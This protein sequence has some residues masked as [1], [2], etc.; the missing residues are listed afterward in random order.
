M[1]CIARSRSRALVVFSL[2]AMSGCTDLRSY[3]GRWSGSVVSEE[4]VRQGFAMDTLADPLELSNV[5]LQGLTASLTLSDGKFQETRLTR[6]IRFSSD[7]MASLSFEG[8]PL[9][10]YL[11]FAPLESE[12]TGWPASVV[13]SL[14]AD[15]H[16]ELRIIRGNDLFGVFYLRRKA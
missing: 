13:I 12:P 3:A 15:D 14:F 2:A 5:D 16:V 1:S 6:V 9:R 11:L 8:S 10:S 7:S 4:A